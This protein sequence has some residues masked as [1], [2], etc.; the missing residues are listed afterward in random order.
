MLNRLI[1]AGTKHN[2][3]E[4]DIFGSW[5]VKEE[6]EDLNRNRAV[7]CEC[8]ECG[9]R[10]A[11]RVRALVGNIST[12]CRKC[13]LAK[14]GQEKRKEIKS[15]EVFGNRTVIKE[16][17][18]RGKIRMFLCKC[19]CGSELP[20]Q[21]VQL[22]SERNEK[23]YNC[24]GFEKHPKE[25]SP[26]VRVYSA[27]KSSAQ[28]R[29]FT[30]EL[31][32]EDFKDI[33]LKDCHYC[34]DSAEISVNSYRNSKKRNRKQISRN[35]VDRINSLRGYTVDNVAPCCGLCNAIKSNA[36]T[37]EFLEH[38]KKIYNHQ[39]KRSILTCQSVKD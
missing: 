1:S 27:Y 5:I 39:Q 20:T 15:G 26:F 34:G 33:M 38:V 12:K 11:V 8:D 29:G 28:R 21:M 30:F 4:N 35:G 37:Q 22:T 23:C 25:E 3:Y 7:L 32:Y 2:I 6:H 24:L 19:V 14:A 18:P 9:N 16:I 17:E 10:K 31:S 36:T 13:A